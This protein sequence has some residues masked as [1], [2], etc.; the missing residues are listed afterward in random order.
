MADLASFQYGRDDEYSMVSMSSDGDDPSGAVSSD[1]EY[2]L[3]DIV[4]DT[5][6]NPYC[7][8]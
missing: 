4:I 8:W 2:D 5:A 3:G 7:H 1:H 6:L